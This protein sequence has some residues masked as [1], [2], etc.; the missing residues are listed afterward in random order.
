MRSGSVFLLAVL[1]AAAVP[2]GVRASAPWRRAVLVELYTSQGCSSCPPA[3]AFVRELPTLGLGPDKV[4]PLTFHVDYWDGLGWK[5]PF[6]NRTN[7]E[8]QQWYASSGRLRSPDGAGGLAGLY[9]PQMIVGGAVQ[10]SGQRRETARREMELAATRPV[11]F[12]L[13][14]EANAH[15][16]TVDLTARVAGPESMRPDQD[17]RAVAALAAKRTRTAVA[18]GEN[19]GETLD[20]ASVVRAL[21]ERMP[22]A[23]GMAH[24]HLVKPA[25]Q[26][27]TETEIVVFAQ[28]ETTREVGA[29]RVLTGPQL[30]PR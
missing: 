11:P 5:D 3:D 2:S 29:V 10:F 20:E 1:S 26:T 21:S 23:P 30:D 4:V 24:L 25:S 16:S 8:R 27:W 14:V 19:V 15:G 17:W 22:L 9:T 12:D 28:S 7:T 18:R 13:L 6:S